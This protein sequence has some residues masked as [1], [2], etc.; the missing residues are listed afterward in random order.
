MGYQINQDTKHLAVVCLYL[1]AGRA[2]PDFPGTTRASPSTWV[3]VSQS[4]GRPLKAGDEIYFPSKVSWKIWQWV[5]IPVL[6]VTNPWTD[7]NLIGSGSDPLTGKC[8]DLGVEI[9]TT[10]RRSLRLEGNVA[11]IDLGDYD[12]LIALLSQSLALLMVD[13]GWLPAGR[14]TET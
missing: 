7:P 4:T 6:T 14:I 1:I 11:R 5:V 2:I 13:Q 8:Y 9:R 12:N 10:L 3:W